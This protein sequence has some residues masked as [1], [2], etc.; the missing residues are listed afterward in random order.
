[1]NSNSKISRVSLM[2]SLAIVCT[3]AGNYIPLLGFMNIF[4]GSIFLVIGIIAGGF[5]SLILAILSYAVIAILLIGS[6]GAAGMV[7]GFALPGITMGYLMEKF[8]DDTALFTG[9]IATAVGFLALLKLS[10][11]VTGTGFFDIYE[12]SMNQSMNMMNEMGLNANFP[13]DFSPAH[14]AEVVKYTFPTI[15][16]LTSLITCLFFKHIGVFLYK[17]VAPN[18][19]IKYR[20]FSDFV[21]PDKTGFMFAVLAIALYLLSYLNIL[22]SAYV[23]RMLSNIFY[24][25]LGLLG[26]QGFAVLIYVVGMLKGIKKNFAI[27]GLIFLFAY[28]VVT[29]P[30]LGILDLFL[31]LRGKSFRSGK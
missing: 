28:I 20:L 25:V 11:Y 4:V 13:K 3:I 5:S 1:M 29:M 22:D 8:D 27:M 30:V 17:K 23:K 26:V 7:L 9:V 2:V 12:Q 21:I 6:I 19:T 10:E 14:M 18:S 24:I 31:D 15:I 16:L